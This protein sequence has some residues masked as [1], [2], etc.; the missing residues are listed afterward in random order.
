MIVVVVVRVQALEGTYHRV[1]YVGHVAGRH[2]SAGHALRVDG[3][4]ARIRVVEVRPRRLGGRKGRRRRGHVLGFLLHPLFAGFFFRL[5][6]V[7]II[8]VRSAS[9]RREIFAGQ[10]S[11]SLRSPLRGRRLRPHALLMIL[12]RRRGHHGMGGVRGGHHPLRHIGRHHHA[13]RHHPLGHAWRHHPLGHP[14]RHHHAGRHGSGGRHHHG[15]GREHHWTGRRR[16]VTGRRKR[17][18]IP[19]GDRGRRP[20]LLLLLGGV[21]IA[22]IV[23][24]SRRGGI[25]RIPPVVSERGV[26][27]VV[28][29]CRRRRGRVRCLPRGWGRVRIGVSAALPL[30]DA[31]LVI[32]HVR[33]GVA[34]SVGLLL[35][36]RVARMHLTGIYLVEVPS[37]DYRHVAVGIFPIYIILPTLAARGG[38]IRAPRA[39]VGAVAPP[40]AVLVVY[41]IGPPHSSRASRGVIVPAGGIVDLG[42]GRLDLALLA[43]DRD[44]SG[45]VRYVGQ[46]GV[47]IVLLGEGDESEAAAPLRES[48]HHDDG[49]EDLSELLEEFEESVFGHVGGQSSHEQ[50][51]IIVLGR[52][53][54]QAR[55]LL[56]LRGGRRRRGGHD[57]DPPSG[58]RRRHRWLRSQPEPGHGN[59]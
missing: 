24:T 22:V 19:S 31:I 10:S 3:V 34:A 47:G 52:G 59:R 6:L 41:E 55:L 15:M 58:R 17:V 38:M 28:S 50:L 16:A 30:R 54:A 5:L 20:L 40:M 9:Q 43:V 35:S 27:G 14:G 1:D 42:R 21:A 57:V 26:G 25:V 4:G 53:R 12:L 51:A 11:S 18:L 33:R 32:V 36:P 49:I 56:P 13:G 44:V 8:F 23:V 2:E 39:V 46:E 7:G 48:I 29:L 45:F 37:V